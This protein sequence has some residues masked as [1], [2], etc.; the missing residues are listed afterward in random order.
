[1]QFSENPHRPDGRHVSLTLA[2]HAARVTGYDWTRLP[3][4]HVIV[5]TASDDGTVRRWDISSI[6]PRGTEEN[7]HS[8]VALH[9]IVSAPVDDGTPVGLTVADGTDVALWNLRTGEHIGGLA[10]REAEP[11]T[12]DVA[13]PREHAPIAVTF[14]ADQVMRTWS[15]PDGRQLGEFRHDRIRLPGDMA[16]TRLPDG[17]CVAVTTGYGRKSVVWDL[18]AGRIRNVL[19]GHRGSSTCVSCAEG[20]ELWPFAVTGG[21]DNRLNVWHLRHGRWHRRFRIVPPWNFLL[22]PSSGHAHSV[23]VLPLPDGDFVALAATAD[24]MV[25]ILKPRRFPFGARRIGKI[26]ARVMEVVTLGTDG[27]VVVTAAADGT[28]QIWS[29]DALTSPGGIGPP[30]CEINVEVPVYDLSCTGDNA[31]VIATPNGLTAIH[32]NASLLGIYASSLGP[33]YSMRHVADAHVTGL[34]AE[35]AVGS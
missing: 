6:K 4:G 12:L 8:Q 15:L 24:E 22:R 5:F 29:P 9:Q 19:A 2:G 25:R 34:E 14:D 7:T 33:S 10:G 31:F 20:R 27:A 18:A 35:N 32:L 16:C 21:L 23:R 13:F 17:T 11:C 1:M 26:H 30:L 28:M 3:D